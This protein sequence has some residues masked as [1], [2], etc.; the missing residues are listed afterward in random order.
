MAVSVSPVMQDTS[1]VV[2]LVP[3]FD[4][5][6]DDLLEMLEE[7]YVPASSNWA[8]FL[9]HHRFK[10]KPG[11]V[12]FFNFSE[13]GSVFVK[14]VQMK[15]ICKKR[16]YPVQ[17]MS[18]GYKYVPVAFTSQQQYACPKPNFHFRDIGVCSKQLAYGLTEGS[19]DDKRLKCFMRIPAPIGNDLPV[20]YVVTVAQK[21]GQ[22]GKF[23]SGF[24]MTRCCRGV[25]CS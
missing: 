1:K 4:E 6:K 23:S 15:L 11:E 14:P 9:P 10:L 24:L 25:V 7:S 13:T 19:D 22:I 17:F 2:N 21:L 18:N 3:H 8:Y 12:L 5:V 16:I 20:D